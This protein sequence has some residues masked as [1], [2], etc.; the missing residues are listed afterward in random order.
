MPYEL[1][2]NGDCVLVEIYR[3]AYELKEKQNNQQSWLQGLYFY[4][5]LLDVSPVIHAF[6]KKGTTAIPYPSEPYALTK[7]DAWIKKEKT[8][9]L[10]YSTGKAKVKIWA[11]RI[12]KKMN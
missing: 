11:D 3:K 6:A 12:N 7:H 8:E 5:A 9:Q 10:K 1:F 4:E 2:W